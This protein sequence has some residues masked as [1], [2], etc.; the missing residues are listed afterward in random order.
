MDLPPEEPT[1]EEK[2]E[3]EKE[4]AESEAEAKAEPEAAAE[5]VADVAAKE[6]GESTAES[7]PTNSSDTESKDTKD[8]KKEKKEK[9]VKKEK[10][11]KKETT[12]RRQLTIQDNPSILSPPLMVADQIADSQSRI[13]KLDFE[14]RQRRAKEAA[15]NE[16]EGY[17]YKVKNRLMDE[18]KELSKISTEEQRTEVMDLAQAANDWLDDEGMNSDVA[19]YKAKQTTIK[20]PAEAIFKRISELTDRPAVVIK[21]REQLTGV[22]IAVA[23]WSETMPQ[24]TDE[25]KSKLIELVDKAVTWLDEKEELQKAKTSF[26]AAA[27][28]SADVMPQLKMVGITFEK[29]LKKPKPPPEKPKNETVT[30]NAT[31]TGDENSTTDA[32]DVEVE[33][34]K[35]EEDATSTESAEETPKE[36]DEL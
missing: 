25:E 1:A 31:V 29:L 35:K 16:L 20:I 24:V 22:K 21:A 5:D 11:E 34:E 30:V 6:G 10:K 7:S 28:D 18:E 15:L 13:A 26:E 2:A 27:F 23:K 4:A 32:T 17:I 12:L 36:D 14:D 8:K 9:K 33:G 19:T 3:A